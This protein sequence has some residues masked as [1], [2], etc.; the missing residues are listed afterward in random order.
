MGTDTLVRPVV[1]DNL[2]RECP[3]E[4]RAESETDGQGDGFT[5]SGHG[6]VFNT[7]TTINSWEGQFQEEI[8][9]GAF[10]R[11]L[12]NQVPMMQY[13]HGNHPLI[14][15]IPLGVWSRAEEDELGV[16]VEGRI[17]D[18]WL[19][20]PVRDAIENKGIKGMSFRFSVVREVWVD[21]AGTRIKDQDVEM[22]LWAPD[23]LGY[24][25]SLPLVRQLK[26]VRAPE[27]GPVAWPQ[28]TETDV[29]VRSLPGLDVRDGRTV[30]IDLGRLDSP[31]MRATLAR[32]VLLAD[33][34]VRQATTDGPHE[35][36]ADAL[37][38]PADPAPDD[39]RDA[40]P[41]EH[42]SPV[43]PVAPT[44]R[45]A[46]IRAAFRSYQSYATSLEDNSNGQH[47]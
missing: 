23:R 33:T 8:H 28:Y 11:T 38:V 16:Y 30:V 2:I 44:T 26:E 37:D 6:A 40:D 39:H 31:V 27:I 3:F 35:D 19:M 43:E 41:G 46:K 4:T 5:I 29:G 13:D 25:V 20:Q 24:E 7:R 1:R 47:S 36:S 22:A 17:T 45:A 18:N 14:G 42:P 15:S 12:R 34:A 32:A 9:P 10:K 21:Q